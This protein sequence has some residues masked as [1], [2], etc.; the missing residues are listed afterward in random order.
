MPTKPIPADTHRSAGDTIQYA[1]NRILAALPPEE[2]CRL[3]PH[4]VATPLDYKRIVSQA[5]L[6]ITYV[7]FPDSGVCSVMSV[8][9]SGAAAEVATVGNE[10]VTGVALFYGDTTEP[11]ESIIQVPGAG[12]LLP[13]EV[14]QDELAR[15]GHFH[16][17]I[18]RYAHAL[19]IQ[20]MQSAGC[21]ALHS[22]EQ[23][24]CKWLLTTHDRVFTDQFR[25]T[26]EFLAMMLGATRQSVTRVAHELQDAGLISYH[27]GQVTVRN[28]AGLEAGSCECYGLVRD[29]FDQF[30]KSL[31]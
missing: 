12:H 3:V 13:A 23:R 28:R 29:Y 8:M 26:Q 4:L 24:A 6:P 17:F 21:N 10:G 20:I 19:T 7:C 11:S 18:G 5:G 22:I 2:L 30:L 31:S 14:F 15:H 9:R 27:R 1:K 16:R 25:L